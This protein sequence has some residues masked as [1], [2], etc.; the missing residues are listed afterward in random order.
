VARWLTEYQEAWN[1][2]DSAKLGRML[3]LEQSQVWGLQR[4]FEERSDLHVVLDD[5]HI[6]PVDDSLA[7]AT[8]VRHDRWIDRATGQPRYFSVAYE[9]SFRLAGDEV[10]QV[11]LRRR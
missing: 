2:R 5:V 9:Q 6:E 10:R 1:A 11:S 3:N 4:L 8:Y 7:R